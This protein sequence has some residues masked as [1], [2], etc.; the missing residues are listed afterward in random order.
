M[1]TTA[2]GMCVEKHFQKELVLSVCDF[3]QSPE[4]YLKVHITNDANVTNK[5]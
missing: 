1:Q 2:T 4:V 5:A 3:R